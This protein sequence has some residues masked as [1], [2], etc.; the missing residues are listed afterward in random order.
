MKAVS[1]LL[2]SAHTLTTLALRHSSFDVHLISGA[3][4]GHF[5]EPIR[6][7]QK[8]STQH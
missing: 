5:H 2:N 3:L 6:V 7:P 4:L 8:V 1:D